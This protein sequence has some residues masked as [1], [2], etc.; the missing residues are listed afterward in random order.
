LPPQ[1]SRSYRGNFSARKHDGEFA[2]FIAASR[3]DAAGHFGFYWG[4]PP[5][6]LATSKELADAL[7]LAWLEYFQTE[8]RHRNQSP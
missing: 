8:A 2:K 1:G 4:K 7:M 3:K 6:E 5:A